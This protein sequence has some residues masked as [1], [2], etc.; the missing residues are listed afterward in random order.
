MS[1][2]YSMRLCLMNAEV[3]L[4]IGGLAKLCRAPF[5]LRVPQLSWFRK[6]GT[7]G[8]YFSLFASPPM[9]YFLNIVSWVSAQFHP[10]RP[11]S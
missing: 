9:S 10:P 8:L 11:L 1:L 6:L 5:Q 3:P 2:I 4:F 7:T